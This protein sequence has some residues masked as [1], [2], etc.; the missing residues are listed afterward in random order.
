LYASVAVNG[1]IIGTTDTP[2]TIEPGT[3]SATI[4]KNGYATQEN[5]SFTIKENQ[6]LEFTVLLDKNTIQ[7][8]EYETTPGMGALLT[9]TGLVIKPY[10]K[11]INGINTTI[12]GWEFKNVGD[13]DWKGK[14]GV[15][16]TDSNGLETFRWEGDATKQQ[17]IL[18]GQLKYLYAYTPGITTEL[19][20]NTTQIIALLTKLN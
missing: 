6:N 4:S 7:P 14:V 3:Y 12:F 11:N 1:S 5:V 15:K 17:T 19:D 9:K 8:D 18:S 20:D 16:L 13:E 10:Q 2:I